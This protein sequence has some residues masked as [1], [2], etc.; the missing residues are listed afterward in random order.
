MRIL[1]MGV[2]GVGKSTV[3]RE[4]AETLGVGFFDADVLHSDA[5]LAKMAAGVPLRMTIA[6]GG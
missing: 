6:L 2:A 5:N 1:I 4:L 3:G